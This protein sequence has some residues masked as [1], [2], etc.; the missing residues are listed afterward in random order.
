M[1]ETER[2]K[3]GEKEREGAEGR[4][5]KKKQIKEGR[6]KI[7]TKSFSRPGGGKPLAWEQEEGG[8]VSLH[9]AALT[10]VCKIYRRPL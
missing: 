3:D 7:N 10:V 6:D 4:G 1:S 5:S 9:Q 8:V 2:T